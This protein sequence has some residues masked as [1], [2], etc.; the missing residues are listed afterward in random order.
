MLVLD[1]AQIQRLASMP[2]LIECLRQAFRSGGV[3]PARQ[4]T[5]IPGGDGKRLLLCMPAFD[6]QGRGAV[7]LLT[8]VPE[9]PARALPTIQAIIAVFSEQGAPVAVVDG[10]A[11]T[12]LRTGATSAL[13]SHYLSR[14]DSSQLLL[15]GTGAL[16]PYMAMAHCAARPISRVSV[17]GRRSERAAA[18][19]AAIRAC[20]AAGIEV[21]IA[22]SIEQAAATAD[23]VCC[24]TS[25][26][27]PLLCG[28]WLRPGVFVDLVGSFT[29]TAR[30]TDDDVVRRCRIFV[31]TFEGAWAEAGDILEPLSR[32]VIGRASVAGELRDL[33]CGRV[34][35]R[36]TADELTLFKSVGS[37]IEDLAAAQL[38]VAAAVANRC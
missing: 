37:A 12:R 35:G 4:V 27:T 20:V 13:A 30:E 9:N 19:A 28:Q 25:S 31:D 1:A 11:V 17:W 26:T 24:A 3:A 33:V 6:F 18:T 29:P 16:A 22:A 15:I 5:R 32:G 36:L 14:P 21:V 7:K 2:E 34:S 8:I 10:T 23:I 38:L